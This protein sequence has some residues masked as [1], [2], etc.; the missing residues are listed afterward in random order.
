M[1]VGSRLAEVGVAD[2]QFLKELEE[3]QNQETP[4]SSAVDSHARSTSDSAW[5]NSYDSSPTRRRPSEQTP[6]LMRSYSTA[7]LEGASVEYV[8]QGPVAG[9]TIMGIHNLAIVLPQFIIAIVASIIFRIADGDNN[10]SSFDP[11]PTAPPGGTHPDPTVPAYHEKSGVAWVLRFGGLMALIGAAI[12]RRVPPTKQ[13]KT[14]RRRLAEMR[15]QVEAD[16]NT[17]QQ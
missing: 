14:M 17:H 6:L 3:S 15:E 11:P 1:A 10:T 7:D 13:E 2:I 5:S 8:G 9:G 12:C 4:S 16:E